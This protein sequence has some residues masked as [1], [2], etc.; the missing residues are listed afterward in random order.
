MVILFNLDVHGGNVTQIAAVVLA[1]GKGTRMKSSTPKV[2]HHLLGKPMLGHVIDLLNEAGVS[3]AVVVVGH[4]AEDVSGYLA[5]IDEKIDIR[6]VLQEEQLGT[7]HA[8]DCC[9]KF[10]EEWQGHILIICG[11]TPLFRADTI[12]K[13]MASHARAS[14]SVSVLSCIL[15][16]P[17]GYGRIIRDESEGRFTGIVEEKD[18]T[19]QQKTIREVNSGTYMVSSE[20]LFS[21]LKN[22][23]NSNAQ[24]EY[25]LTDIVALAVAMGLQVNAYP[26][27][28]EEEAL[29]I[30]SRYQLSVAEG[31]ML[32]RLRKYW[33]DRGVTFQ[34][35][36]TT[37]IEKGVSLSNDVIIEPNVVMRGNTVVGSGARIGA[38]SLLEEAVIA[39]GE[40]IPP[41]SYLSW[42][43]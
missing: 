8:V 9:R 42:N 28:T 26:F 18:A 19:A 17:E 25:Y 23:D 1:A 34:N 41:R 33:M 20:F 32:S 39:D 30:N 40:Q 3:S 11:D 5:T 15:N 14:N 7:G 27:A 35:A 31:V 38:F 29:G 16:D 37:Y 13:F 10:F 21:A 24:G 22:I 36:S 4:G 43:F 2:L 6:T 12:K